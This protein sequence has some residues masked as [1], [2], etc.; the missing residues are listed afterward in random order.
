[1]K[2]Y[3]KYILI[4]IL[5]LAVAIASIASATTVGPNAPTSSVNGIPTPTG[6]L[7]NWTN[8]GN[9]LVADGV[10]ATCQGNGG[11]RYAST[12]GYGFSIP[13][14]ARIDGILAEI[15]LKANADDPGNVGYVADGAIRLMKNGIVSGPDKA[16]PQATHWATTLS[17]ISY[18]SSTDLWGGAWNADEINNANFGLALG[19]FPVPT[20]GAPIGSVD[21]VRLTV[22]YTAGVNGA[23]A[24][25]YSQTSNMSVVNSNVYIQ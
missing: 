4:S 8:P 2:R 21:N 25:G 24:Q 20:D 10:F 15:N 9:M 23:S 16:R 11:V 6:V 18:G 19:C 22:Y 13:S 17:Y 12:T 1:M 3:K 5:L 14:G 7:T